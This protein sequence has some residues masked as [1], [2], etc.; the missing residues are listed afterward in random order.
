MSDT[1]TAPPRSR[2]SWLRIAL[3]TWSAKRPPTIGTTE[4]R[5]ATPLNLAFA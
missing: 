1:L 2:R 3:L 5:Y 4:P